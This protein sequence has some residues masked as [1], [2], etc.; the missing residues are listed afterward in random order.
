MEQIEQGPLRVALVFGGVSPEHE[1][2]ILSASKVVAGLA[3]LRM[4]RPLRVQAIYINRDGQWL[5]LDPESA[6]IP[7]EAHLAAAE[8]WEQAPAHYP[9]RALNFP[10]SLER[11]RQWPAGVVMPIMHGPG[12]EDGRLQAALDLAELPYTGSGCAA[13][14][15]ALDKPRAQAVLNAAGL[16][17]PLSTAVRAGTRMEGRERV[18]AVVGLP[19]V[20]KPASGGSSVGI[21]LVRCAQDLAGALHTAFQVDEDVM[22][23]R[24]VEGRELTCGVVERHGEPR[25]CA[26]TEIIPPEGRFFDYD[27]KYQVGVSR[28]L[29][30]ARIEPALASR[31]QTLALAAHRCLGCRGFS[32]VD[33]IAGEHGPVILEVNTIPGM[34]ATSLL[35]QGAAEIGIGFSGLLELMLDA[36][37]YDGAARPGDG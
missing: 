34:T 29:T 15:L 14:A 1:I 5:W 33:F 10:Q 23:E 26:V 4:R 11:L 12:G 19:C 17:V 6:A 3:D 36:A 37:R 7:E 25:P 30:P 35:P 13:S 31:I 18:L 9:F 20:V 24:F 28:E 32:R 27:A 2:S 16:P 8:N 21:T 22:V